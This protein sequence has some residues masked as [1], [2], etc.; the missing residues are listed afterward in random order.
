MSKKLVERKREQDGRY[1]LLLESESAVQNDIRRTDIANKRR[2]QV[3][4]ENTEW[5]QQNGVNPNDLDM[6]FA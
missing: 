4:A 6:L 1:A 2:Q 3:I 5:A